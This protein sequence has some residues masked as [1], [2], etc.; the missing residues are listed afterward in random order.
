MGKRLISKMTSESIAFSREERY[1]DFEK[2][3][4]KYL[5]INKD[6]GDFFKKETK[7]ILNQL[8]DDFE[9]EV[10]QKQG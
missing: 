7:D 3:Y 8:C 10:G 9:K 5:V 1:K 2:I 6:V 4:G